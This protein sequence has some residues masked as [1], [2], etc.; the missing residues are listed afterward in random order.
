LTLL[1]T[2]NDLR[3][4]QGYVRCGRC[5]NVFNAL[6]NLADARAV[7][8]NPPDPSTLGEDDRFT[9]TMTVP[10]DILDADPTLTPRSA[11]ATGID[12]ALSAFEE[13]SIEVPA[14]VL[15]DT[16]EPSLPDEALE[17]HPD[18][19]PVSEIF[20]EPQTETMDIGSGTFESI[21]LEGDV[22]IH[23]QEFDAPTTN[24]DSD[25]VDDLAGGPPV[26]NTP[27]HA[28]S[29]TDDLESQP[30]A[31]QLETIALFEQ[32]EAAAAKVTPF[33]LRRAANQ[34]IA[35]K[36]AT[37]AAPPGPLAAPDEYELLV[38]QTLGASAEAA[39]PAID[40]EPPEPV[41]PDAE[42]IAGRFIERQSN[43]R[44]HRWLLGGSAALV[45][46]FLVQCVHHSRDALAS[47]RVVGGA[48]T[49]V[50]GAFGVPLDPRWNVAA[51]EVRQL[52]AETERG[53][54]SR[55]IIRTS[56]RNAGARAQPVPLLRLTLQD[57]YGNPVATRDL[58]PAEYL[59][60]GVA[61]AALLS[62]DQRVDAEVRVIDPGRSA[63]G[64]EV[65]A[66]LRNTKGNVVCGND[67]RRRTDTRPR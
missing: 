2:A 66:C 62:A 43:E 13:P 27:Q 49:K 34:S 18:S 35:D 46:L 54:A 47:N 4:G 53:D 32:A 23:S 26:R 59:P 38:D 57:R 56:V 42:A 8:Q 3:V 45:C 48:V 40:V 7:A 1:V 41:Y 65:D 9:A 51:Y 58:E 50:Y 67:A 25:F 10:A 39:R 12:R 29:A 16:L 31:E 28:A 60:A 55:L 20:V 33:D 21:I 52:G 63:I 61:P 64:F 44:L 19:T 17:F 37:A 11:D 6:I 14:L 15:P 22:T 30:T 36:P 24:S 5:S